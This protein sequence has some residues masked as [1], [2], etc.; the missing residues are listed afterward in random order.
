MAGFDAVLVVQPQ[1]SELKY[2]PV[3]VPGSPLTL[4]FD[5]FTYYERDTKVRINILKCLEEILFF[6]IK[7]NNK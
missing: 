4:P 5:I 3:S 7:T 2:L 1:S 6:K